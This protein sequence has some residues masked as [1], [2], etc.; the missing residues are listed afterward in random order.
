MYKLDPVGVV[1]LVLAHPLPLLEIRPS[2]EGIVD[3]AGQNQ[4]SC[5][6]FPTFSMQ[7]LHHITQLAE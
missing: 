6:T 7:S 3:L 2:T 1:L 4:R 5:G